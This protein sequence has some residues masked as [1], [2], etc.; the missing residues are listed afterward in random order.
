MKGI[1]IKTMTSILVVANKENLNSNR[2]D[3]RVFGVIEGIL[4]CY[5]KITPGTPF[6][7]KEYQVEVTGWFGKK[8]NETRT[9]TYRQLMVQMMSDLIDEEVQNLKK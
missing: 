7:Y 8:T 3:K 2:A 1:T 5:G 6:E 9:Q 4:R